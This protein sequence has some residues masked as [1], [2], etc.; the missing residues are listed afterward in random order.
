MSEQSKAKRLSGLISMRMSS[1]KY[2]KLFPHQC[3]PA[4]APAKSLLPQ[5]AVDKK[6]APS[7][8]CAAQKIVNQASLALISNAQSARFIGVV[9]Q[10]R[11]IKSHSS[12]AHAV[13]VLFSEFGQ[14]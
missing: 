10:A 2:K 3:T 12:E 4:T 5:F 9:F 1:Y 14:P 13:L 7:N 8:L 6:P 11:Q